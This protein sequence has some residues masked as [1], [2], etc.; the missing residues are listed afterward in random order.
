MNDKLREI[1]YD[2]EHLWTGRKAIKLLQ[3]E[4][5][6]PLKVV[7]AWLGLQAQFQV[8][9]PRPKRIDHAHFYVTEVN[10]MHQADLLY[11]PHDKVYQNTYK[12]VLNIIDVAS[13][14]K[15]SRPLRTKKASEVA[16]MFRDMYK[17]GPLRYPAEL[18][19]DN[20]TEFKSDVDKLMKEHDVSV[21]RVTTKYHH[22]FTAFV[23]NFNKTLQQRL[24]KIQDAQ[25]LNNPSKDSKT[26]VKHLYKIVS[27]LNASKLDRIGMTPAKAVKLENVALK[28]KPYPKEEEAPADGL[29]R[30]LYQP[31]E[32]EGG[33]RRRATDMIWSWDTFRLD[34]ITADPG[35]RVLYYLAEG[36]QRA[37]VREELMPIPETT[38]LPPDSV[39][40]W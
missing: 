21:K 14:Y 9:L 36:P 26:W 37:F 32:L 19:V 2:P 25:E 15:V 22:K 8:H 13:G 40:K 17:K 4:S 39:K 3:K 38:E 6:S 16:D 31:G 33:Q 28:L 7:K 23:E 30:Y 18:H 29:Y 1:Y 12:Y 20:G 34:R 27:G 10:K 5:G 35:Q 24:F 11:L